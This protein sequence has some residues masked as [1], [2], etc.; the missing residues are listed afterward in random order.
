MLTPWHYTYGPHWNSIRASGLILC[1]TEFILPPEKPVIWFS[2]NQTW[3]PTAW[4]TVGTKDGTR[5]DLTTLESL[6]EEFGAFRI[7]LNPEGC[8]L[9]H[10]YRDFQRLAHPP[11]RIRKSLEKVA[12]K[13][14]ATPGRWFFSLESIPARLWDKVEIFELELGQWID[15]SK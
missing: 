1:A 13:R 2:I 10:P 4:K 9:L 5:K 14:G 8:K 15:K 6:A 11:A 7:S 3:E 12:R